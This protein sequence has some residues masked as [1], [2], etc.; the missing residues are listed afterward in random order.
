[1]RY[2]TIETIPVKRA[3]KAIKQGTCMKVQVRE[4]YLILD[5]WK[6]SKHTHRYAM[7]IKT[8][9][10]AL[11]KT[12]SGIWHSQKICNITGEGSYWGGYKWKEG[13]HISD[14]DLKLLTDTLK[15]EYYNGFRAIEHAEEEYVEQ[16]RLRAIDCKIERIDRLMQKIP[17]VPKDFDTWIQSILAGTVHYAFWNKEQN[18]YSC[19]SCGKTADM[20]KLD[21]SRDSKIRNK[22][23]VE[24]P[25]CHAQLQVQ[26]RCHMIEKE[27]QAMLLSPV[28]ET[29]SVARH[30]NIQILWQEGRTVQAAWD[31][32]VRIFLYKNNPKRSYYICYRQYPKSYTKY[33]IGLRAPWWDT[34]PANR[35]MGN[36]FLYPENIAECLKDTIYEEYTHFFQAAADRKYQTRYN[37]IMYKMKGCGQHLEYLYKGRYYRLLREMIDEEWKYTYRMRREADIR[38]L[39][40]IQDMQLLH[41]LRDKNGG[42]NMLDWLVWTEKNSQRISDKALEF[43]DQ[44]KIYP[45]HCGRYAQT[46]KISPD[47]IMNYLV[48]Q[49][50]E[51]YPGLSCLGVAEQWCD[52]LDMCQGL[53]KDICDPMVYRPRELKRRHD[54]AVEEIN[55]LQI[56][57]DMKDNPVKQKQEA[58]ELR[59]QYPGAEEILKEIKEKYEY[60][61]K[62]FLVLV[63]QTLLDIVIE[64]Q[65][66]HHCVAS[67]GRYFDRILA[68]ETYVLFLRKAEDP[69]VPYYTL[70]VEPNGTIRQ[71]RSY[72][73]EEPNIEYI[74]GFLKEWQ[75]AIKERMSQ[76]DHE[77]AENSRK[78]REENLKELKEN[79]N[80]RVLKGLEQ[81]FLEAV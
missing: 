67:T 46:L 55:R 57:E 51:Q 40:G 73:D 68:R 52:Y 36:E 54:K 18:T 14:R 19:T 42:L 41:R 37:D 24:C 27:S 34:N 11:K 28:D 69:E 48:R 50:K 20:I 75:K 71:H 44:N 45:R 47:R 64:G 56:I 63:P 74:R 13:V 53:N 81:D 10:Y 16:K 80:T 62:E 66:L 39:T 58:Q 7:D 30:F 1:M 33:W 23:L 25:L 35:R 3:S 77:Y 32:G 12:E 2:K 76:K 72:L 79:N 29:M 78:L 59:E 65:A 26:K 6:D 8:H 5:V 22:D 15:Q 60:Q 9:E 61:T 43:F 21:T 4:G 38:Q 49:Q 31:E 17:P 70:E